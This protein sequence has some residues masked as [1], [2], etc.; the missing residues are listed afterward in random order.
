MAGSP[1]VPS[2][3]RVDQVP[4]ASMTPATVWSRVSPSWCSTRTTNGVISRLRVWVLSM[5]ARVTAMTLAP[6][7]SRELMAG[8]AASGAR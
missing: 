2:G 8:S 4:E 7:C 3:L 6:V 5:P 1:E